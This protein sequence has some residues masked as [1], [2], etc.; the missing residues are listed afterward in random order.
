MSRDDSSICSTHRNHRG[1]LCASAISLP[2]F[3]A[4]S[5]FDTE[6]TNVKKTTV[7][8][9]DNESQRD[10]IITNTNSPGKH[11]VGI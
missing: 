6:K 4:I 8:D 1:S 3:V 5:M 2:H 9:E 7:M 11:L 10:Y